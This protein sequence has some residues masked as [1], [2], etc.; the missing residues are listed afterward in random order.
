[1]INKSN[2]NILR[3]FLKFDMQIYKYTRNNVAKVIILASAKYFNSNLMKHIDLKKIL[4]D[5][6]NKPVTSQPLPGPT[7]S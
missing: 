1:M 4:S 6:L 3:Y 7:L 2:I 5:L